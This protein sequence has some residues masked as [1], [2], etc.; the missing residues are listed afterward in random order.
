MRHVYLHRQVGQRA[1]P[2]Q[3][4]REIVIRQQCRLQLVKILLKSPGFRFASLGG[5]WDACLHKLGTRADKDG[6]RKIS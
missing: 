1:A 5:S 6:K 4:A 2:L 3:R